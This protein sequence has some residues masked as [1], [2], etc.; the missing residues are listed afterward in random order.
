MSA[1]TSLAHNTSEVLE[2]MISNVAPEEVLKIK[3][4]RYDIDRMNEL[5]AKTSQGE[6]S[7]EE[8]AELENYLHLG[9]LIDM[10]H[11]KARRAL[12]QSNPGS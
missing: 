7:R 1:E 8:D 11:S 5:S 6:L 4:S 2:R 3:F 9:N 12:K 10:M